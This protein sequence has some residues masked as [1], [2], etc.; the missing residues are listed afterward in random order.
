[1]FDVVSQTDQTHAGLGV[2]LTREEMNAK[3]SGRGGWGCV[4][5]GKESEGQLDRP[6]RRGQKGRRGMRK[7]GW[8]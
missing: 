2:Q 3:Y 1:M 7:T 4:E 5:G 8:E 6:G